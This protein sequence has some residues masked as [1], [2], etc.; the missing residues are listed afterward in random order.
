MVIIYLVVENVFTK[1]SEKDVAALLVGVAQWS[2]Y[3]HFKISSSRS[4][5]GGCKALVVENVFT[6]KTKG[7]KKA[8]LR[9]L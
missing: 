6:K 7:R 4:V 5:P 8:L 3:V 2:K 9:A 1:A